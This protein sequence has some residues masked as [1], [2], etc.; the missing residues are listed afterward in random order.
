MPH[1]QMTSHHQRRS[2]CYRLLSAC[3][4]PP[5][6]AVLTEKNLLANLRERL[7]PLAPEAAEH[8]E[9]IQK[10]I[11]CADSTELAVEHAALFIG[12]NMLKAPPYGSVYLE[13]GRRL[14]GDTTMAVQKIYQDFGLEITLIDAPDHIIFELEFM[15]YLCGRT[16]ELAI[17]G[18]SAQEQADLLK[19]QRD[20]LVQFLIKWVPPFCQAMRMGT[21]SP[22]YQGLAN[23]LELFILTETRTLNSGGHY[24]AVAA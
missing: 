12:P 13:E 8:C 7:H 10:A 20:F 22:F 15:S 14:L 18:A 1:S 16:V 24:G 4:Y 19:Q 3:F 11:L 23:T 17:T 2:D 21:D 6:E 5:S 9:L